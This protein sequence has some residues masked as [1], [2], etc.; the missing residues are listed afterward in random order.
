VR[1][2][3]SYWYQNRR[4]TLDTLDKNRNSI[5]LALGQTI[6]ALYWYLNGVAARENSLFYEYQDEYE[7]D[8][9]FYHNELVQ[10][11]ISGGLVYWF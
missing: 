1:L 6:G 7:R 8:G 11:E 2:S 10:S 9:Y 3:V 5:R 4:N